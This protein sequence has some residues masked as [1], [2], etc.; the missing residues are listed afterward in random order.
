[1]TG[2]PAKNVVAGIAP[3]CDSGCAV[4][5]VSITPNDSTNL[6]TPVRGLMVTVAGAV[7]IT[8]LLGTAIVIPALQPGIVYPIGAKRVW[9]ASTVATG[10]VGLI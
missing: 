4:D 2:E 9:A 7:K 6:T 5:A 3:F 1:M 10:I 8:T